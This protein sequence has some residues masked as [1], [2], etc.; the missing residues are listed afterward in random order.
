MQAGTTIG[1]F[2][3]ERAL[4]EGDMAT[5]YQVRHL[6]LDTVHALKLLKISHPGMA[7]RLLQEGRIQA[8]L[9]HPNVVAVVDVVQD[10]GAI[11]L[12]MEYV[13]GFSLA[14]CLA[15]GPM[16]LDDALEVFHQVLSAVG[17]AHAAGVIHRDLKPANILLTA[18]GDRVLAKVTDFGIAKV[19]GI[20]LGL[21]RTRTGVAMGTP[22]YLAPE[23][24][25]GSVSVDR[26]ADI[27]ALG[28]I[29]YEM[30]CGQPV[31]RGPDQLVTMNRT[32]AGTYLRLLARM[33]QVPRPLSDAI[34]RAL[35]GDRQ[36]RFADCA[37][38]ARAVYSDDSFVAVLAPASR[39]PSDTLAPLTR[40]GL[41]FDE[42]WDATIED[43]PT[44]D[45]PTEDL[46]TEDMPTAETCPDLKSGRLA[47][48]VEPP[49]TRSVP[50]P[51]ASS[52][53]VTGDAAKMMGDLFWSLARATLWGM[54]KAVKYGGIPLVL[55]ASFGWLVAARA[56][57]S[58]DDLAVQRGA[59]A[60]RLNRVTDRS[61]ERVAELITLGAN[62]QLLG[63]LEQNYQSAQTLRQQADAAQELS[64]VMTRQL[65]QLPPPADDTEITRRRDLEMALV[66]IDREAA[67]YAELSRQEESM[68]DSFGLKLALALH[69]VGDGG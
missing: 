40:S 45:L 5:V 37:A 26:R 27:F 29:L 36:R 16:D 56:T 31:F 21:P 57:N 18:R 19:L 44:D 4:G 39:A 59:Q 53:V 41:G 48:L 68:H 42:A 8:R 13:D 10:K 15:E 66:Q 49:G 63:R 35:E 52:A 54:A 6:Q 11:G 25:T 7:R 2:R 34:D 12:L 64:G 60:V 32:V 22:G 9:R 23:Q 67:R 33:P 47:V 62:Q 1:R 61:L 30:I 46:P 38:F 43:L 50:P 24:I 20:D 51:D 3:I 14:A 69:M 55:L 28:T 58:L 65:G 17:A